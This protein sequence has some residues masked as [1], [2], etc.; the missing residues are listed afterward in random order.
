MAESSSQWINI[1]PQWTYLGCRRR[2]PDSK[3]EPHLH[4][5]GTACT[6]DTLSL[7][8]VKC[9]HTAGL[10]AVQYTMH[11]HNFKLIHKTDVRTVSHPQP[12]VRLTVA[13]TTKLSLSFDTSS[14]SPCN[15][16]RGT[17]LQSHSTTHQ[18]TPSQFRHRAPIAWCRTAPDL[19]LPSYHPHAQRHSKTTLLTNQTTL[20]RHGFMG[21]KVREKKRGYCNYKI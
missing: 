9:S 12:D 14:D 3:R 15:V 1:H 20:T 5:T 4:S 17:P 16:P 6:N 21:H 2:S 13:P 8:G 10:F 19:H 7:S 11:H 18:Q